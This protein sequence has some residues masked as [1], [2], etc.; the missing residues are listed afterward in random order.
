MSKQQRIS[1]YA[2]INYEKRLKIV[3]MVCEKGYTIQKTA[4]L[5]GI[6]ASTARMIL[7]K[8]KDDGKIFE[9][10]EEQKVREITERLKS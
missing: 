1:T 4:N 5:L 3:E 2:Y 7:K 8:Y 10:K 9:R 6:N